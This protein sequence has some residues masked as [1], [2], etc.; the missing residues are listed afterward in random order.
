MLSNEAAA[1]LRLL[2]V[3]E[4]RNELLPLLEVGYRFGREVP[5]Q[6]GALLRL[7]RHGDYGIARYREQRDQCVCL[8]DGGQQVGP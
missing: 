1:A 7:G 5:L 3:Y 2:F 4:A 6:G 8:G